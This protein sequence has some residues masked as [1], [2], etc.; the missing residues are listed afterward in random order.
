M[1]AEKSFEWT[2]VYNYPHPCSSNSK[3]PEIER[4][5]AH[6]CLDKGFASAL[7]CA[8]FMHTGGKGLAAKNREG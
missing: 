8:W 6:R 5:N 4:T 2:V 1:L 7:H 3:W